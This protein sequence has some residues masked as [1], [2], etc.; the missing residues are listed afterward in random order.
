M[1]PEQLKTALHGKLSTDMPS[2]LHDY[3]EGVFTDGDLEDK[4]KA[5][6]MGFEVLGMRSREK[7]ENLPTVNVTFNG[8]NASISLDV[9]PAKEPEIIDIVPKVEGPPQAIE[10]AA[11]SA[12]EDSGTDTLAAVRAQLDAFLA[13]K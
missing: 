6:Y 7:V 4:R 12:A 2:L 10:S 9:E 3:L 8:V 1:T 13:S 5:L 11:G